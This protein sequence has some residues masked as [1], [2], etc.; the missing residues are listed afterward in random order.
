M[1]RGV[2]ATERRSCLVGG[3]RCLVALFAMATALAFPPAALAQAPGSDEPGFVGIQMGLDTR[4]LVGAW[5]QVDLLVRGGRVPMTVIA[6]VRNED[7]DGVMGAVV[8]PRPAALLPGQV[9]PIRLY[10]KPGRMDPNFAA[11]LLRVDDGDPYEVAEHEFESRF[12]ADTMHPASPLDPKQELIVN[13]GPSIG[14]EGAIAMLDSNISDDVTLAKLTSVESLPTRWY[15][16]DGVTTVA[17]S[18]SQPETW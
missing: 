4:Y 14:V 10:V 8:S 18:T 11:T 12:T 9:T 17:L 5:T 6:Q 15:G 16:Y 2:S 3:R 1:S 13:V 7:G